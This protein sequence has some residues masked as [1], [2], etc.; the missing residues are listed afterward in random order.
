MNSGRAIRA[1]I[2]GATGPLI[3][4]IVRTLREWDLGEFSW[5]RQVQ[6]FEPCPGCSRGSAAT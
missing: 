2:E 5:R 1:T 4:A 6:S 3:G